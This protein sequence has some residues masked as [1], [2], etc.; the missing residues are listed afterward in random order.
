[1]SFEHLVIHLT[2]KLDCG[3][4]SRSN[5]GIYCGKEV[6]GREPGRAE[7]ELDQQSQ[8]P[9]ATNVGTS[10]EVTWKPWAKPD[11]LSV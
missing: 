5:L 3:W 9:A 8:L 10:Q 1:M 6:W 7:L 4:E 2:C 11:E